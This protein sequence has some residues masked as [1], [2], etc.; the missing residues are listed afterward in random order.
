MFPETQAQDLSLPVVW[1]CVGPEYKLTLFLPLPPFPALLGVF[2]ASCFPLRV[3]QPLPVTLF[4]GL[5]SLSREHCCSL[6]SSLTRAMCTTCVPSRPLKP[7]GK[8]HIPCA[9]RVP[10]AQISIHRWEIEA[11]RFTP[12][13][14]K[15]R[16]VKTNQN[17]RGSSMGFLCPL[18]VFCSSVSVAAAMT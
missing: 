13:L 2:H 12:T 16:G 15:N 1:Q 11:Q 7:A 9:H 14:A 8:G 3:G 18:C 5:P 17:S 4:P 6:T 10:H